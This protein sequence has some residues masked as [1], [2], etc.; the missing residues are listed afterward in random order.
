MLRSSSGI[1]NQDGSSRQSGR[2]PDGAA[3]A[4][5]VTGRWITAI[6]SAS[7]AVRSAQ[8]WSWKRSRTIA[9]SVVPSPRGTDCSDSPSVLPGK[10][11]ASEMQLSPG[12]G[13]KA[14]T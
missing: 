3:S 6:R 13:A 14:A 11:P 1:T 5:R 4:S 10:R 7:R 8:N 9:R 12:S 2:A